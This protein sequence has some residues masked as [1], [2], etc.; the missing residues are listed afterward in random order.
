[1]EI[2]MA[3][4]SL[5]RKNNN[6]CLLPVKLRHV[7]SANHAKREFLCFSRIETISAL[8]FWPLCVF[9]VRPQ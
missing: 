5:M 4:E 9:S 8:Q 3:S 6:S 7:Y 1:M 2:L